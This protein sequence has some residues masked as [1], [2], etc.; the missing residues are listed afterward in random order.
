VYEGSTDNNPL[1]REVG[2]VT[3]LSLNEPLDDKVFTLAG[4]NI[5]AGTGVVA[6]EPN[7]QTKVWDWTGEAVVDHVNT[8]FAATKPPAATDR[9][10]W[11][12]GAAV[13]LTVVAVVALALYW[14]R[15]RK[16]KVA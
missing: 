10:P 16:P 6:Q 15:G 4:M 7:G 3:E 8:P 5:A 2:R 1:D 13:G 12:I 9:H 14:R 11:F